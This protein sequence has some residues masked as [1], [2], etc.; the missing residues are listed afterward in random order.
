MNTPALSTLRAEAERLYER[1]KLSEP[2]EIAFSGLKWQA[3]S[4]LMPERNSTP[5]E[6]SGQLVSRAD[7]LEEIE[8][9]NRLGRHIN[10]LSHHKG[11]YDGPP[12]NFGEKIALMHSE[13]SE[14]LEAHRRGNP[15]DQHCPEFSSVE[16]ELADALIRILETG[17]ENAY[18]LGE[19]VI[20]KHI[21]NMTRPYKHGK[22]Y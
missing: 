7:F 8:A 15:S 1:R 5:S 18:R 22:K 13:L 12:P 10:A 11:F 4:P 17:W 21:F 14:A 2:P 9:L 3:P 20:A 19:A 6:S 16:I